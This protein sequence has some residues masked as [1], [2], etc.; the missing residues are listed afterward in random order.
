MEEDNLRKLVD[1]IM[2]EGVPL[3]DRDQIEKMLRRMNKES[4]FEMRCCGNCD[5]YKVNINTDKYHCAEKYIHESLTQPW[6]VCGHW[7]SDEADN[8]KRLCQ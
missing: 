7:A 1:K 4:E 6:K 2:R 8:T 3:F 5:L